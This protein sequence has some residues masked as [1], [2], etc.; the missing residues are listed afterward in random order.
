MKFVAK[1]N[2]LLDSML[3]NKK[4]IFSLT[5]SYGSLLNIIMPQNIN[6]NI[7]SFNEVFAKHN[8]KGGIYFAHKC[9]KSTAIIK[10]MLDKGIN[11]EVASEN[12]LKHALCSGFS[13]NKI[14]VNGPKNKNFLK[15]AL[16]HD[17]LINV[18]SFEELH[19]IL[20]IHED[21]NKKT[22]TKILVRLTN[23]KSGENKFLNNISK[24]GIDKD[25]IDNL[26]DIIVAQENVID[27]KGYGF[28]IAT[29]GVKEKV[30]AIENILEIFQKSFEKD[31]NPS[32]INIGGGYPVNYIKN[33]KIWNDSVLELTNEIINGGQNLWNDSNFG[34]TVINNKARGYINVNTY[35]NKVVKGDALDELLSYKSTKFQNREIGQILS[36][37]M[38]KLFIE[39]GKSLLDNVGVNLVKVNFVKTASD[40]NI[41]VGL[42]MNRGNYLVGNQDV[43][44]DPILI[45][46]EEKVEENDGVFLIGNLC[47]EDDIL[48]RYKL[49][50]SQI[51]KAGDL[52]MFINS[53]AYLMDFKDSPTG[54]HNTAKKVIIFK[55]EYFKSMLDEIYN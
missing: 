32:I 44:I 40:G 12:E 35:F 27:L 48:F 1:R 10:E 20:K 19:L 14:E 5:E 39:P 51:P 38:I 9:N 54:M 34:L 46:L 25:E 3:E 49:N 33:E 55:D 36:D 24:F 13:Y 26:L 52:I 30:I 53:A 43:L 17:I 41:L 18:D 4:F 29:A 47:L 31:L 50:F 2:N 6:D 37:N 21:I 28:H 16:M 22:K 11:I 8:I 42:D 7:C 23:F 45:P 15:L